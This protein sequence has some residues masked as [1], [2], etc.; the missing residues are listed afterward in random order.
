[1][2][3]EK[4]KV[5]KFGPPTFEELCD[6]ADRMRKIKREA[7]LLPEDERQLFIARFQP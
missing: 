3:T 4:E 2:K 5:I 6:K 7:Q 1:M